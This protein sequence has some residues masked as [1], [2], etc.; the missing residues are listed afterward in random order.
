[1]SHIGSYE[2]R[3]KNFDWSIAEKE[4]GYKDGDPINIGW[5]CTDRICQM[6]KAD[7]TA[8]IWEGFGGNERKYS[9]NDVRL[10]SNTMGS[11]LRDLGIKDGDRVCLFMDRLPELYFGFLA[12]LKIGAI[13][14]PLFSAFGDESLHV[15]LDNAETSA[16]ITQRKHVAKVRKIVDKSP[17]LKHIIVVDY[18]GR[19]PLKEREIAFSL[20]DATPVED[21]EVFPTKAEST[22]NFQFI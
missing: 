20:D 8:L 19:K 1:M 5:Y 14:Q 9:F 10:A 3:A 21:F 12:I 7:K 16:I 18:D 2:E 4:L 11:F 13:A 22:S 15:R 6:G 17:Y